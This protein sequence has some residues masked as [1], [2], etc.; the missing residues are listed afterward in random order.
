MFLQCTGGLSGTSTSI[1]SQLG[2]MKTV[3][4]Q[5][6]SADTR[7]ANIIVPAQSGHGRRLEASVT[8][9]EAAVSKINHAR[10]LDSWAIRTAV[11]VE[12]GVRRTGCSV[13]RVIPLLGARYIIRQRGS[14]SDGKGD[15][16]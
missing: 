9:R 11:A 6:A 14:D 13:M 8:A 7:P 15:S 2:Q 3:Q 16:Y 4:H 5:P 10:S 1:S 12:R